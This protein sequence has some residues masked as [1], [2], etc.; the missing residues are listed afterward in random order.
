MTQSDDTFSDGLAV[1]VEQALLTRRSIRAFRD[2]PVLQGDIERILRLASFAPSGSNFQPWNVYVLKGDRRK[3]LADALTQAFFRADQTTERDYQ[4]YMDP[5]ETPYLERRR[6]CGW[7][8]YRQLGIQRHEKDRIQ[9]QRARNYRFFDAP[10]A[11]I[12]TID[13]RL[14]TGSYIDYG[15]FIQSVALAARER[16]L[17]TCVQASIAE[18]PEIVRRELEVQTGELVLC[19]MALGYADSGAEVNL[20]RPQRRRVE[21]FARFLE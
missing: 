5:M 18:Y 16:G 3:R 4:Y 19:G 11:L 15:M 1:T 8:L 12:F 17:H 13:R 9:S 20:Y 7:G 14:A 21:E 2:E 6:A 10:V